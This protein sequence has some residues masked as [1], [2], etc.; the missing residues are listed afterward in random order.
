MFRTSRFPKGHGL[1]IKITENI[2]LRSV[3]K[4]YNWLLFNEFK[5]IISCKINLFLRTNIH[6]LT[7]MFQFYKL[8]KYI[9]KKS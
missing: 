3:Y 9:E 8:L 1:K 4:E 5:A 2:F 6:F 7:N